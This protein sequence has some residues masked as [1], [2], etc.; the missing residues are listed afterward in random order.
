MN[1]K[2][3]MEQGPKKNRFLLK[4]YVAAVDQMTEVLAKEVLDAFQSGVDF[5]TAVENALTFANA[6]IK[7]SLPHKVRELAQPQLHGAYNASKE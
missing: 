2:E 3:L 5:S 4:A 7:R 1:L 6:E